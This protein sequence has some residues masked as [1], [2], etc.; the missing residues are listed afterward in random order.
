MQREEAL[1]RGYEWYDISHDPVVPEGAEVLR[2]A[3]M[4]FQAR[5]DLL[6][7]DDVLKKIVICAES[8]RPFRIMKQELDFYRKH[9][10]HLP[11]FHFDLRH[12]KRIERMK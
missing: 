11:R 12:L 10:I 5:K 7:N 3:E 9:A 4:D 8:G 1:E 2:P 6:S